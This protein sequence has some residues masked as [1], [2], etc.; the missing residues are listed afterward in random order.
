[1]VVP[2]FELV[3]SLA[4]PRLPRDPDGRIIEPDGI[5]YFNI[6]QLSLQTGQS[7]A[8]LHKAYADFL[9]RLLPPEP[10]DGQLDRILR[11]QVYP[12]L[13]PAR[14]AHLMAINRRLGLDPWLRLLWIESRH[15]PHLRGPRDIV[16]C[17]IDALRTLAESTGLYLGQTSPRY[18]DSE[19]RWSNAWPSSDPPVAVKIGV[20]RKGRKKP[21]WGIAYW[22]DYAKFDHAGQLD[23]LYAQKP[24]MMLS[25]CAESVALRKAFGRRL[26]KIYSDVEFDNSFD[27]TRQRPRQH[28]MAS[29]Q[30]SMPFNH[31]RREWDARYLSSAGVRLALLEEFDVTDPIQRDLIVKHFTNKWPTL[32]AGN[33]DK[34]YADL[35][36]AVALRPH[37]HGIAAAQ[38]A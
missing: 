34:F 16:L 31:P 38:S 35:L 14:F 29:R 5:R 13:S 25:T 20:Y 15:D 7:A 36:D 1:M 32:F 8:G 18:L 4:I 3:G 33:P 26:A 24:R 30:H 37:E 22:S 23:P 10:Q 11:E 6:E 9:S 19:G 2:L 21:S 17:T 12:E 27:P 28:E